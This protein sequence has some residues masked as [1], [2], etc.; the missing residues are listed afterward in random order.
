ML[1]TIIFKLYY[2]LFLVL[3]LWI[4]DPRTM[5]ED[6]LILK[7]IEA[8]CTSAKTRHTVNSCKYWGMVTS[9]GHQGVGVVMCNVCSFSVGLLFMFIHVDWCTDKWYYCQLLP[10]LFQ[11][12]FFLSQYVCMNIGM[13]I[14]LDDR[15]VN[16]SMGLQ[17]VR[18]C[19]Y[20]CCLS[21]QNLIFV[22][23]LLV[24]AYFFQ[25][26]LFFNNLSWKFV[27]IS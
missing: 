19:M 8:Y 20:Y 25:T 16:Q 1:Y 17:I 9:G 12:V 26:L 13:I 11:M 10:L 23:H 5:E 24:V 27:Y 14:L 4:D 2:W 3:F 18:V 15:I 22:L 6:A 21:V 7:V